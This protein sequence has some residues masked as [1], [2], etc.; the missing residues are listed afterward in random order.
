MDKTLVK[1]LECALGHVRGDGGG[2][3][4]DENAQSIERLETLLEHELAKR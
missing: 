1:A 4:P 3:S 2:Y